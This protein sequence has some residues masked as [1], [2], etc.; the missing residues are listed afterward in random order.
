MQLTLDIL[1]TLFS[2]KG[3][4]PVAYFF[5]PRRYAV[6]FTS[7]KKKGPKGVF[8]NRVQAAI[9]LSHKIKIWKAAVVLV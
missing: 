6:N 7:L 5:F 8:I 1:L 4:H 2:S 9:S 3:R